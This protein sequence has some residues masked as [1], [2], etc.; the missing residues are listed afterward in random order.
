MTGV[1]DQGIAFSRKLLRGELSAVD[2]CN[3]ALEK[4]TRD[5][6]RA[7]LRSIRADHQDSATFLGARIAGHGP[8]P[9]GGFDLWGKLAKGLDGFAE[10]F[11]E[12]RWLM[13][14]QQ[15]LPASRLENRFKSSRRSAGLTGFTR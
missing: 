6:A 7:P 8:H 4:F 9:R 13:A 11:G 5:P 1:F 10:L 14:F 12:T 2:T 3:R 15:P